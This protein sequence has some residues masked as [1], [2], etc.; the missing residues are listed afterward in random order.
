MLPDSK[1]LGIVYYD[2]TAKLFDSK[3]GKQEQV[4]IKDVN[5][6]RTVAYSRDAN[7]VALVALESLNTIKLHNASTFSYMNTLEG[8]TGAVQGIGFSPN[9][10]IL[11][12]WGE[13]M[14]VKLWDTQTGVVQSLLEPGPQWTLTLVFP[15]DSQVVAIPMKDGIDWWDLGTGIRRQTSGMREPPGLIAFSSNDAGFIRDISFFHHEVVVSVSDHDLH[16]LCDVWNRNIWNE[17]V[18]NKAVI[19]EELY[20]PDHSYTGDNYTGGYSTS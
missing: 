4:L 3:T 9:N 17:A 18:W 14:T 8:H 11:A 20:L 7:F 16:S 12:S 13:D 10:K 1:L 19:F 5:L 2:G 15:P 6:F